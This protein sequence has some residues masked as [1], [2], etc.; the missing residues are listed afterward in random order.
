MPLSGKISIALLMIIFLSCIFAFLITP[1]DPYEIDLERLKE[2]PSGAHLFGTDEK[3]RDIFTR[4]LYGGRFSLG[5]AVIAAFISFIAGFLIGTLSGYM[6]G[7]IDFIITAL[8]DLLLAFPSLLLAIGISVI[9]P[10]SVFTVMIAL[11]LTEWPGFA[12]LI[13][14]YVMKIKEENYIYSARVIGCGEVRILFK[15]IMPQCFSIGL[16]YVSMKL[17]GFILSESALSFLGLGAQP[18]V[19]TW[20]SMV[21]SGRVYILGEPWI[22]IFPGLFIGVTALCFNILGDVL[23]GRKMVNG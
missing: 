22:V 4:I 3:G 9:M 5:V 13:R 2:P 14:G 10:Q 7:R 16:V 11:S 20:G 23:Q 6:G 12:R 19:P 15:H 21:S 8:I 17:G 1:Y 18:P